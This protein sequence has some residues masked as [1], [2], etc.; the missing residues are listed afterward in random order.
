M[1]T[2]RA[3]RGN[4][5]RRVRPELENRPRRLP[6]LGA[7]MAWFAVPRAASLPCADGCGALFGLIPSAVYD[8]TNDSTPKDGPFAFGLGDAAWGA[9]ASA[10]CAAVAWSVAR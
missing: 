9:I 3:D 4:P 2:T 10:A 1:A 5:E 6:G 8:F 7:G